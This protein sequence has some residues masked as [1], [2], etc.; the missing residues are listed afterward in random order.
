MATLSIDFPQTLAE[1]YRPQVLGDFIGLEKQ[2]KILANLAGRGTTGTV[3]LLFQGPA[4]TGKTSCAFAFARLADCEIHHLPSQDCKLET[5]Q[6]VTA[7]CHRVAYDWR[8]G[9]ARK[10]HAIL[11]DEADLLHSAAQNFLL[12][13]LD[14]S[15]PLPATFIVLTSNS[16]ERF[17]PRLLQRLIQLPKFTGYNTS[18]GVKDL[19]SRVWRERAGGAPEPDFSRVPTSSVREALSWLEVELLSV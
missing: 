1:Q 5:L 11:I 13:R 3:G 12:S 6:D 10:H 4:G 14:G 19:L 9:C 16:V 8:V 17:E 2:R 7:M 18:A 15:A